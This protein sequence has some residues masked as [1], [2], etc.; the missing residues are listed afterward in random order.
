M[1]HIQG[2]RP[3]PPELRTSNRKRAPYCI[4]RHDPCLLYESRH[5]YL[6]IVSQRQQGWAARETEGGARDPYDT[7]TKKQQFGNQQPGSSDRKVE[8]GVHDYRQQLDG[9]RR[10]CSADDG[11]RRNPPPWGILGGEKKDKGR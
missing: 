3:P 9:D 2:C 7:C 6:A 4:C 5:P 1:R 11:R 10:P 8:E